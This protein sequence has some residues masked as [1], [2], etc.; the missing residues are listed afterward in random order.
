MINLFKLF[1][2]T[3]F[4]FELDNIF[5][6]LLYNNIELFNQDAIIFYPVIQTANIFILSVFSIFT[7]HLFFFVKSET[8]QSI[9]SH[10][11]I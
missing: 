10:L 2:Y 3:L 5:N 11:F 4:Y 1:T 7:V 8:I 6:N 9:R